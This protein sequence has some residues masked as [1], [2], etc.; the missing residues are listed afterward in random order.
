[1]SPQWL[2]DAPFLLVVVVV[3]VVFRPPGAAFPSAVEL[4]IQPFTPLVSP[5]SVAV[6]WS[7]SPFLHRHILLFEGI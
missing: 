5:L 3:S 1:M 4:L 7:L 6:L 2:L